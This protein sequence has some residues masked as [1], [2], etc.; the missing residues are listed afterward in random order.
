MSTFDNFDIDQMSSKFVQTYHFIYD[1]YD[2]KIS[3]LS[4]L[5]N[6]EN[7]KRQLFLGHP[8]SW[9]DLHLA[10]AIQAPKRRKAATRT[11]LRDDMMSV[12]AKSW[13]R[14]LAAVFILTQS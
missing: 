6:A 2:K 14:P 4:S 12:F 1:L 3:I 5:N 10:L 11:I 9:W 13:R 8:I 7:V